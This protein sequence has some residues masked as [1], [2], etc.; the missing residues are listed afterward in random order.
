MSEA[1]IEHLRDLFEPLGPI[2]ARAMFGGHGVYFDGQI[3]GRSPSLADVD[4]DH[5]K[6]HCL[7]IL[8]GNVAQTVD[9][10]VDPDATLK[11]TSEL[12]F[13]CGAKGTRTPDPHTAR[14]RR[15]A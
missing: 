9:C 8:H 11:S 12:L 13:C 6:T 2:S 4:G 15:I 5:V 1:L 3:I 14:T 7:C 10:Y